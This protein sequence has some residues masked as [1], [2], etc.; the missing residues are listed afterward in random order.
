MPHHNKYFYWVLFNFDLLANLLVMK[1]LRNH[2]FMIFNNNLKN[3]VHPKSI[4]Y[5]TVASTK[6]TGG[7]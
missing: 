4:D 1:D 7:I 6:K 3:I 2:S 5:L